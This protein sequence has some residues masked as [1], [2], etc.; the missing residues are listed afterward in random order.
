[1]LGQHK[2]TNT[3][4]EKLTGRAARRTRY[5]YGVVCQCGACDALYIY[6]DGFSTFLCYR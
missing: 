4:R 5:V 6:R 2:L 3:D 1:V